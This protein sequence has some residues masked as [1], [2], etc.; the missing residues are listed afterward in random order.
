VQRVHGQ[1]FFPQL[2]GKEQPSRQ[3]VHIE[4]KSNRQIRT[5][6]WI[7]TGKGKLTRMNELGRPENRPQKQGVHADVR[8]EMKRIFALID[9][10]PPKRLEEIGADAPNP[11]P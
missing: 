10:E 4:Y 3:W 5:K 7:Y 9:G 8:N 1:S 11:Q 2:L 6:E